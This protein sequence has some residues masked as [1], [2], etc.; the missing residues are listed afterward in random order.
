MIDLIN[1]D[2]LEVMRG[3]ESESVDCVVTDPP[4]FRIKGDFDFKYNDFNCYLE[5][6]EKCA[7]EWKRLLKSS[8]SLYVFCHAKRA[9]YIQIILDKYFKLENN[10]VWEKIE[11]RTK[12][13]IND[14]R[15][16]AP[17]TERCLF[18]S[19]EVNKTGLQEIH[20]N[21]ALFLPIKEYMRDERDK[22]IKAKG[23][24]TSGEFNLYINAVTETSSV[25][26][27]HYFSDSQYSF[28]TAK[29]Y[30]KLQTTGFFQREYESLRREYESLR[31]PFNNIHQLT[32]V[33]KH[34]Q[35]AHISKDIKHDTVKPLGL[36]Q[37]LTETSTRYGSTVLDPFMG[38]GTTGIACKNLGRRFIGIEIDA[39]YYD[40]AYQR[41]H[42]EPQ[43]QAT[44]EK[45]QEETQEIPIVQQPKQRSL[46]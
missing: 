26:S 32:D 3:L 45:G 14:F 12:L 6:I 5:F 25:V 38:S 27:R 36:I 37:K 42:Q 7:I 46:F 39:G 29:L 44:Q 30:A 43:P 4:Y 1:G 34:S 8:G 23:F 21:P 28:P 41:I 15:C 31:R 33:I 18:Y 10:L 24:K 13:G 16:Y 9:A 2:C 11:C 22:L 20:D 35:E 17:I 19:C 40:I